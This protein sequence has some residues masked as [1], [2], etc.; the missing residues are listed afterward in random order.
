[1]GEK[2]LINRDKYPEHLSPADIMEITG[3]GERAVYGML[4]EETP[5]FK[6]HFIARKYIIPKHV[7][8]NW[9]EGV[10]E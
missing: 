10:A 6:V 4:K 8:F 3:L 9:F 5:P 7:F 2:Q 1:M